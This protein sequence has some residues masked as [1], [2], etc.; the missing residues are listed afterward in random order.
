MREAVAPPVVEVAANRLRAVAG[1]LAEQAAPNTSGFVKQLAAAIEG[2]GP[3]RIEIAETLVPDHGEVLRLTAALHA[4]QQ[5]PDFEYRV[6]FQR[7]PRDG[8]GWQPNPHAAPDDKA[9]GYEF[10]MRRRTTPEHEKEA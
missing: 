9:P 6:T 10:W 2:Y 3:E 8:S 5:H 1:L 4:L 7:S